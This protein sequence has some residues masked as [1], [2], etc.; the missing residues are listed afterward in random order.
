MG[1]TA[2]VNGGLGDCSPDG[3]LAEGGWCT[4]SCDDGYE[5]KG[6]QPQCA[7]GVA[8]P[9]CVDDASYSKAHPNSN[10]GVLTQTMGYLLNFHLF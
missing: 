4:L 9:A 7:G 1:I 5:L 10:E 6:G 2:P 8:Y 3:M